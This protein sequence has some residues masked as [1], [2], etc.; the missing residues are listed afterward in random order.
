MATYRL[1]VEAAGSESDRSIILHQAATAIFQS[2][3]TAFVKAAPQ[4][5]ASTVVNAAIAGLEKKVGG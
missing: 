4:E 5:G 3:D 1:L 2:Q